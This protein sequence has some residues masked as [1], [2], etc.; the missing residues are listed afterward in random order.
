MKKM[1]TNLI[2][3]CILI[4]VCFSSCNPVKETEEKQEKPK[5]ELFQV[6]LERYKQDKEF[7]FSRTIFP[8]E[9]YYAEDMEDSRGLLLHLIEKSK[10]TFN[11]F[12]IRDTNETLI[13][14]AN[15]AILKVRGNESAI[16][17][18]YFFIRKGKKWYLKGSK[19]YS[20]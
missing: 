14:K 5:T 15:E 16:V 17:I 4:L 2:S 19:D 20:C 9:L 11:D 6:F 7:Q 12:Y 3:V 18:D 8:Y 13:I 1:K 10:M